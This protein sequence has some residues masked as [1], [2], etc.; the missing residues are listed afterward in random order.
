MNPRID[1]SNFDLIVAPSH[2]KLSGE[3]I[4]STEIAISHINQSLINEEKLKF[5]KEFN[6]ETKK[7]CTFLIGGDSRNHK[8][9]AKEAKNLANKINNL[10]K[11]QDLK[12]IVLFSRRTSIKIKNIIKN[13]L[14]QNEIIWDKKE[15]PYISLMG[16]SDFIV[17]TSDSVS[18][19]SESISSNKSVFIYKL[20][21]RK[22]NNRIEHFIDTVLTKNYAKLLENNLYN[23][24][25][26]YNNQNEKIKKF[27][28]NKYQRYVKKNYNVT[29][30]N[31]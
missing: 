4:L 22:K 12:I 3:N 5:K 6:S 8:F 19:I 23:F 1:K 24:D 7:I 15:N 16:Y 2:D 28:I 21:S 14:I 25:S 9:E 26:K 17:C 13:K 10:N 31:R 11:N 30:K 29:K 18:M 27:I 20:P